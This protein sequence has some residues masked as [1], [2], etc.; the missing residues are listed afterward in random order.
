MSL[1][2][3]EWL[4]V[5]RTRRLLSI[6]GV[7]VFFGLIGPLSARYVGEIVNRFA[8]SGVKVEFPTPRPVD[9]IAQFTG[10]ATQLGLLVVVLVAASA[11]AFDARREMAVF[12]RTRVGAG[13]VVLVAYAVN[14][15]AAVAGFAAGVAAAWYETAVLLGGP[16]VGEMLVGTAYAAVFLA[17]AIAVTALAASLTRSPLGTAGLTIAALLVMSVAGVVHAVSRWLPTSLASATPALMR[18]TSLGYYLG[19]AA[20]AVVLGA[21]C[22]ALAVR[23]ARRH[24]V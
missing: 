9:G 10:N 24:E 2:R 17:F 19:A 7:Y 6:F 14:A 8:S 11:L 18:G 1:W 23:L 15:A 21:G 22:L 5:A 13:S 12:L 16:P 3:L 20:V 4:R